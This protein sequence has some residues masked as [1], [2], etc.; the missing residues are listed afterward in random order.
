LCGEEGGEK[1][2]LKVNGQKNIRSQFGPA[3]LK[4]NE[5]KGKSLL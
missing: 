3:S 1:E 4:V 5:K 2:G